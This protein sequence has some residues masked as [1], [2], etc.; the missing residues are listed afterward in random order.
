MP[1][2]APSPTLGK[3]PHAS[4]SQHAGFSP[5]DKICTWNFRGL[6]WPNKQEDLK[7]FLHK[8]HQLIARQRLTDAQHA[9]SCALDAATLR[10][11]EMEARNHYIRILSSSV[12]LIKQQSKAEWIGYGDDCT[13][14]FFARAKQR[15]LAVYVYSLEDAQGHTQYGF[16]AVA[17]VLHDYYSA[18]LGP[19]IQPIAPIDLAI[20]QLGRCLTPEQQHGLCIPFTDREIKDAIFSIPNHKSPVPDGYSSGFFKST[21]DI[22][23]DMVSATVRAFFETGRLPPS[24]GHTKL[25]LIP[26]VHNPSRA[27]DF[28]PISCCNT[29]Y[30]CITK[31]LCSWLKA[32]LPHLVQEQQGAFIKGREILHNVLLC[33]DI[34]RGYSRAG[35]SPRCVIK[36]DIHKAFDSVH[37]QFI[38]D[39]LVHLK[40]LP[41]FIK[42]VMA[43]LKSVSFDL[44]VNGTRG[45]PSRGEGALNK[46]TRSPP[47]YSSSQWNI[48]PD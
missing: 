32:V 36:L 45:G 44:H 27:T 11:L 47:S 20:I 31:L 1:K 9:L 17:Q 33:Q 42:L 18:L 16:S 46:V 41:H 48:F 12:D 25:V 30:K 10:L 19:S 29:I 40:F 15:K 6:N 39:L 35:I 5:M 2:H 23:G 28:R 3:Q 22:T 26:K 24:L 37:W 7:A 38:H 21:W 14:F 4:P 8:H 34:V 13:R 43:Y